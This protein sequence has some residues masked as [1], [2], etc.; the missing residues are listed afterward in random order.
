MTKNLLLGIALLANTTFST[1]SAQEMIVNTDN[2]L[3]KSVDQLTG[4]NMASNEGSLAGL[5][6]KDL[7]NENI[8]FFC[9]VKS[10]YPALEINLG[11]TYKDFQMRIRPRYVTSWNQYTSGWTPEDIDI[12]VPGK[13]DAWVKQMELREIQYTPA[14][15]TVNLT[16]AF[17][18]IDINLPEATQKIRLV[19]PTEKNVYQIGEMQIYPMEVPTAIESI[20]V[21][22]SAGK[23]YNLQGVAV[24][25]NYKGVVIKDGKKIIK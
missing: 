4:F 18:N 7:L 12:Y 5:I 20:K 3:I 2:P 1:V 15:G 21:E 13:G 23:T 11:A 24:D 14:N 17:T 19:F 25:D 22:T 9:A 8:N 6:D 10:D 16:G